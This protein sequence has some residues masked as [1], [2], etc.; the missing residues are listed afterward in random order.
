M[1]PGSWKKAISGAVH[2][3]YAKRR[4][5]ASVIVASVATGAAALTCV[6][7]LPMNTGHYLHVETSSDILDRQGRL[8]YAFLNNEEQ[9]CFSR[10]LEAISPRLVEATI[11]VEDKRFREH[12]GVDPVAILR[13]VWQNVKHRRVISGASTLTMQVVKRKDG[14][15]GSLLGKAAQAISALRLDVRADKDEIIETYLNTAPYGLNLVGCEAASRRFFGKPSSELSLSEAALLAGLPKAP[16]G[17]MPLKHPGRAKKR[18]NH[19]LERMFAEGYITEKELARARSASLGARWHDLPSFAPHLAMK[20]RADNNAPMH[21]TTT[22]DRDLQKRTE[23]LAK[24]A[25]QDLRGE[26]GNAAV[27]VVDVPSAAILARVGSADFFSTPGGGQVDVC[28]AGRSPGSTLKPFVYGLA[29]ENHLLYG[30]ETLFDGTLDYGR[31]NPANFSGR[32]QGLVTAS[33]ALRRSLNVPAITV[34]DRVGYSTAYELLEQ[35]GVSTLTESPEYYALGLALGS[36]EARLEELA[37]AY[38]MVANM[39][40]Y[41]KLHV[42]SDASPSEEARVFSESTCFKL[43]EMLEQPLPHEFDRKRVST[44]GLAPRVCWKTGTS[45]KY[46]DAWTFMFNRQYLVGVWMGNNDGSSS[47]WLVGAEVA[48]P[49]AS[50]VFKSLER[51][52][53][54]EWPDSA[55]ML[56]EVDVCAVSGLP[57]SK[58]CTARR[59]IGIPRAQYLHRVCDM[60]YPAGRHAA[61]DVVERWPGSAK[62][63]DL[64]SVQAPILASLKQSSRPVKAL[65]IISPTNGAE[66]VLTGEVGGD[67]IK[68]TSSVD[69][70]EELN[71]YL[72]SRYLGKS[73]TTQ[74]IYISLEHGKH[75]LACMNALGAVDTADFVVS[76]PESYVA[77]EN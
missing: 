24:R 25:V 59:A 30:N 77:F 56:R 61:D 1:I 47:K 40:R 55:D 8:L 22:I 54:P 70:S 42:V 18:R 68:L 45:T 44:T 67:R 33:E 29:M 32:Y 36:C 46:R 73:S 41:R 21:V 31:Y 53:S 13:A 6:M 39:G 75:R 64:A 7:L 14:R 3:V 4:A 28:L 69:A 19:V 2:R 35:V 43:F 48:L 49:L 17:L 15:A 37:A 51:R 9:W 16:T 66:Y 12:R 63:W 74:P 27:I 72:D 26:V 34:L 62:K 71:W 52:N 50:R 60:H 5:V 20:L 10:D 76:R 57:V 38:C 58:W 11:A 65:S 23:Y